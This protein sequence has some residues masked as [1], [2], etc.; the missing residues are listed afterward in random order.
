[1]FLGSLLFFWDIS[2]GFGW[3]L[4]WVFVGLLRQYREQI[5]EIVLD[6]N[7]LSIARYV[8]YLVGIIVWL[9]IPLGITLIFP[10]YLNPIAVFAAYF[11]D[12]VLNYVLNLLKKGE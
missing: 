3:L 6:M 12:R 9:A 7:N 4:G 1:M 8:G 5:L 10:D 2:Y 11:A